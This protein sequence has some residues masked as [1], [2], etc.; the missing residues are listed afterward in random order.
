ME[1]DGDQGDVVVLHSDGAL[2]GQLALFGALPP[3]P[4][5]GGRWWWEQATSTLTLGFRVEARGYEDVDYVTEMGLPLRVTYVGREVVVGELQ[6]DT[7]VQEVTLRRVP[8]P[9][10]AV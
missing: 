9:T 7:D 10:G 3:L 4:L 1:D 2:T 8:R 6:G 5:L